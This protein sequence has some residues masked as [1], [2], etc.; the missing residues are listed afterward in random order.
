MMI[1]A[2]G[3][4]TRAEMSAI[5][6]PS[7]SQTYINIMRRV[8]PRIIAE[9]IIGVSPMTGPVDAIYSMRARDASKS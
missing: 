4:L 3:R 5:V 6:Y 2:Q 9:D 1:R 7:I 8:M